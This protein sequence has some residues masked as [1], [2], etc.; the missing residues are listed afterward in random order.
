MNQQKTFPTHSILPPHGHIDF[1]W[2]EDLLIL[3]CRG[4]FNKE[5]IKVA[6]VELVKNMTNR[7]HPSWKRID[8]VD[9]N[10]L[11][12]PE[13]II[14]MGLSYINA[15]DNGCRAMALVYFNSL[16]KVLIE[17]FIAENNINLRAFSNA[18]HAKEWLE[19][20]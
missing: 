19:K 5:G 6:A 20:Q 12:D 1:S 15:F 8:I 11:G 18:D 2:E 3:N 10:A 17:N 16:Q 7:Q 4:P 9:D 14:S 13:V